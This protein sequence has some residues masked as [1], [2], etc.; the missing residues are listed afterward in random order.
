MK[1]PL[2]PSRLKRL[3]KEQGLSQAQ[4]GQQT[5]LSYAAVSR[6]ES[7]QREPH[8]VN[9]DHLALFFE[10]PRE[11]LTGVEVKGL[12][13][14]G[15]VEVGRDCKIG[16][17]VVLAA[18]HGKRIVIGDGCVLGHGVTI[19]TH[20][21]MLDR[22]THRIKARTGDVV[23]GDGC[24]IGDGVVVLPDQDVPAGTSVAPNGV[25]GDVD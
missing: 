14:E 23:L 1:Y 6:W 13:I 24:V 8:E 11:E 21:G 17:N 15:D 12:I 2:F 20:A 18:T 22:K 19:T 7:G 4:L 5:G 25:L 10:V 3:R 16:H 9:I